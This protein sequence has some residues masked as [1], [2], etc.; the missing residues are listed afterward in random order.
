MFKNR[1]L[2]LIFSLYMMGILFSFLLVSAQ[3]LDMTNT[4]ITFFSILKTFLL[5]YWY[6]FIV[7][8]LGLNFIGF[9]VDSFIVYFRGFIYGVLIINLIKINF[10]YLLVLT[11]LELIVFCPMFF[12]LTFTSMQ[13]S[14]SIFTKKR[15]INVNY[16][17]ILLFMTILC[18][19]YSLAL[20]IVGDLYA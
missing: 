8:L 13:N 18:F 16:E 3:K 14:L 10:T 15:K 11:I 17:K 6:L 20:E 9:L 12:F 1:N 2:V 7:W 19:I 5:N 4:D